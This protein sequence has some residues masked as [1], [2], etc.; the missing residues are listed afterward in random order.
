MLKQL[1]TLVLLTYGLCWQSVSW[2]EKLKFAPSASLRYSLKSSQ[3]GIPVSGEAVVNWQVI[4][5]DQQARKYRLSSETKVAI[6][7]KILVSSSQGSILEYGLA[8]DRFIE[9]RFRRPEATTYFDREQKNIHFSESDLSY[10]IQ[11]GEQDRLSA[12]W[13]LVGLV[14]QQAERNKPGQEWKMFVAGLKDADP[15]TFTL[16]EYSKITSALGELNV[17]HIVKAPP[18]DAQGQKLELW[19]A[20]DL[21]YYPVRVRFQDSNGDQVDQKI[22]AI[23]KLIP[24]Q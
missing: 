21:D 5:Q 24:A 22:I 9:K 8:P 6:F 17:M 3:K 15:W 23:N 7:G 19:L 11:G 20:T 2:A 10:P 1:I 18:P 4:E 16:I 12:T 14:R 13:Q